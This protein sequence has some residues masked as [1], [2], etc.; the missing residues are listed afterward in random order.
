MEQISRLVAHK[1]W[2]GDLK[3]ENFVQ[4]SGEFESNYIALNNKQVTRVNIV[5]NVVNKFEN[6]DKSYIGITMDDSSAQIRLKTW[7]EDTRILE[8]ISIGDIVLIIGKI[9]KYN[10]EIY[11]LPEI[12][13]KVS[14]NDEILRKLELIKEYG[15]PE[16]NKIVLIKEKEPEISYEEINFTSNN[17]R[18]EL[19]NLVERYEDKLGIT[20]EEIKLEL[21]ASLDDLNKVLEELLKEGQVYEVKG[22][23]RLLL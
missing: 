14:P 23:Y 17:L 13:K 6:E 1:L 8:N 16:K 15:I 9:K 19:L 22:K 2:L 21:H 20:L 12:V 10:E 3:E 7:R 11:I 5:A 18:N 4:R